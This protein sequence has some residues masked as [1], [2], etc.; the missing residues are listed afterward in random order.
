MNRADLARIDEC[1]K[2]FDPPPDDF[3]E[4]KKMLY[5]A[6]GCPLFVKMK[7]VTF[8]HL[9]K[10]DIHLIFRYIPYEKIFSFF[11]SFLC[12]FGG[13]QTDFLSYFVKFLKILPFDT[14]RCGIVFYRLQF[15]I[16]RF[17]EEFGDSFNNFI[18]EVDGSLIR[19][20][21]VKHVSNSKG[22]FDAGEVTFL[23]KKATLFPFVLPIECVF[24]LNLCDK[25]KI[26][27]L[28]CYFVFLDMDCFSDCLLE[29][30][31]GHYSL[32]VGALK[33]AVDMGFVSNFLKYFLLM[34]SQNKLHLHPPAIYDIYFEIFE[35]YVVKDTPIGILDA[36]SDE[37]MRTKAILYTYLSKCDVKFQ[38][39]SVMTL[40]TI[41]Q[42]YEDGWSASV[43]IKLMRF[44]KERDALPDSYAKR[45][46][47]YEN[48]IGRDI[49]PIGVFERD[50]VLKDL[51]EKDSEHIN[52][53]YMYEFPDLPTVKFSRIE[54][55]K[56][57]TK[58]RDII[59][60]SIFVP[61]EKKLLRSSVINDLVSGK[62]MNE[63]Y[64][65]D[66]SND[67]IAM[68]S[69]LT[70]EFNNQKLSQGNL[71]TMFQFT[72]DFMNQIDTS[73]RCL[74]DIAHKIINVY[75][76]N[77]ENHVNRHLNTHGTA[78]SEMVD[79]FIY[80]ESL[81]HFFSFI[82]TEG[83]L[84]KVT[85]SFELPPTGTEI[86]HFPLFF[87]SPI[88]PMNNRFLWL[89]YDPLMRLDSNN[90]YVYH[91]NLTRVRNI[92][93]KLCEN[94]H[95]RVDIDKLQTL[96]DKSRRLELLRSLKSLFTDGGFK[97]ILK[98]FED[99]DNKYHKNEE[100]YGEVK[101]LIKEAHDKMNSID[102]N[103][104]LVTDKRYK[105]VITKFLAS[106]R[107]VKVE[108][109]NNLDKKTVSKVKETV[110]EYCKK[111]GIVIESKSCS[112]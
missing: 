52:Q 79:N 80:S 103:I 26:G 63:N 35:K 10:I 66:L 73:C 101:T 85:R 6:R 48:Y 54:F 21:V 43:V 44:L 27:I 64:I 18:E 78:M 90:N 55:A 32:L 92:K 77:I 61:F 105:N 30:D 49:T 56:R 100:A 75:K 70:S 107:I 11:D 31:S 94:R 82:Y 45:L 102:F 51:L 67:F 34:H 112:I 83:Y 40:K 37:K 110:V 104:V 8:D 20:I 47:L 16:E 36:F 53:Q 74:L 46:G 33:E 59:N 98:P 14:Q 50:V 58:L 95:Q 68:N 23:I 99:V 91:V 29:I 86:V 93:D 81:V 12:V 57:N 15:L 5:Y 60:N 97:F 96:R 3:D 38:D 88:L 109:Y 1:I 72:I 25:M 62:G 76:I 4:N 69:L 9:D 65:Y 42:A 22:A 89:S 17:Q 41:D 7:R 111:N 2:N 39:F 71:K 108:Q 19:Y 106:N 87:C 84:Y 24:Y 13:K 28:Q